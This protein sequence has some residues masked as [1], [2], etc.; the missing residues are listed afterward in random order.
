MNTVLE[1]DLQRL[2]SDN[3]LIFESFKEKKIFIT[4]GTGFIGKWLLHSFCYANDNLGLGC[5]LVVVSRDPGKFIR[6]NIYF[7]T[8]SDITFIASD[9]VAL[10]VDD[11]PHCDYYIHAATDVADPLGS[12]DYAAIMDVNTKGTTIVLEAARIAKASSVLLLSSGAVY[13]VQPQNIACIPEQYTGAPDSTNVKSAYG[14]SKRYSE[15]L[16]A[17]YSSKYHLR[18]VSARCFAFVGPFLP[19]DKHFAIGNFINDAIHGRDINIGG[20]GTPLRSYMYATDLIKWLLVMLLNGRGGEAYNVGS[21]EAVSIAQLAHTVADVVEPQCQIH[22]AKKP[23]PTV[24]PARYIPS[25]QKASDELG[26]SIEVSLTDA[27]M[28]T[29]CWARGNK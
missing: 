10:S 15:W 9:V 21:E 25:I 24:S 6:D 4:G 5:N 2:I 12:I 20:D 17:L 8:R 11:L 22:I 27:I 19:L 16:A 23:D 28:K 3:K 29:A 1:Q 7:S 26:L 13:G 14:L 18:V